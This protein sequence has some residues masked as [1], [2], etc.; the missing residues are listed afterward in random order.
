MILFTGGYKS[1]ESLLASRSSDIILSDM[2][3]GRDFI[4][5]CEHFGSRG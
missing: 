5:I 4:F 1:L 3:G 2:I